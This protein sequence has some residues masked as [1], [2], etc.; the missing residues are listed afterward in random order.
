MYMAL[1]VLQ[2]HRTLIVLQGLFLGNRKGLGFSMENVLLEEN[3]RRE[4]N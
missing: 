4:K 2:G 1:I 3:C